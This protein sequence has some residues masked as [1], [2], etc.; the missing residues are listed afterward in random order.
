MEIFLALSYSVAR[1][2]PRGL[3]LIQF[4]GQ[5]LNLEIREILIDA[6]FFSYLFEINLDLE[7][8]SKIIQRAPGWSSLFFKV[9]LFH[10]FNNCGP[11]LLNEKFPPKLYSISSM[12]KYHTVSLYAILSIPAWDW[13][14]PFFQHM[15]LCHTHPSVA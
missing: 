15:T 10:D 6:H 12:M 13:N 5:N 3:L 14:H 2:R 7:K 11:K 4:L 9:S 8:F 1:R